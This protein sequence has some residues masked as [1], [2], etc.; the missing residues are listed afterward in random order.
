MGCLI[1]PIRH[2]EATSLSAAAGLEASVTAYDEAAAAAELLSELE[3]LQLQLQLRL[4]SSMT[5]ELIEFH[6]ILL[7]SSSEA[8]DTAR[9]EDGSAGSVPQTVGTRAELRSRQEAPT[10]LQ[11][12]RRAVSDAAKQ[13]HSKGRQLRM[14]GTE[15]ARVR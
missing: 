13:K 1:Q 4:Q 10:A 14:T 6:S 7:E 9:G 2:L 3:L 12:A 8:A 15:I 11:Q 5:P